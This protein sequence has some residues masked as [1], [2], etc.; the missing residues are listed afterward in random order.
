MSDTSTPTP[1]AAAPTAPPSEK[2]V[3]CYC[4]RCRM[5]SLMAP[6]LVITAGF[7]FLID[8]IVP[9]IR[10]GQLWPVFMIVVGVMLLLRSSASVEGH[11]G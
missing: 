8:Q 10:F 5:R 4:P 7:L 2:R 9:G 6:V 11:R 1:T 3:S